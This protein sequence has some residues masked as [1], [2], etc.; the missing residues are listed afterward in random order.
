MSQSDCTLE[1]RP[2]PGHPGYLVTSA[3]DVLSKTTGRPLKPWPHER[4][5]HLRVRLYG[6]HLARRG[7]NNHGRLVT[8]RFVNAYVHV[9]VCTA[10]HGPPP[11]EDALVLHWDDNPANNGPENLRWGTRAQNEADKVR[12]SS[13][14]DD[15]FD[16]AVGAWRDNG[17]LFAG[18]AS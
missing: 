14:D 13:L 3:G 7:C 4:T 9:L 8:N 1:V 6:K 18:V 5:G 15:G 11:F 10:F 17:P 2:V 12:N 16:W